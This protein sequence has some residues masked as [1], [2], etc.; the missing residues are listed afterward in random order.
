MT[1]VVIIEKTGIIK[2]NEC[3]DINNLYKLCGFRKVDGFELRHTWENLSLN[4]SKY[5]VSVY[6]RNDGKANTENKYDMPPP[7]DNDLYYGNLAIVNKDQNNNLKDLTVNEWNKIYE[8]LFGGFENLDDYDDDDAEEDELENIS[9]E[10]KTKV[11]G[12]LKDGFVV[13]NSDDED[14]GEN[15]DDDDLSFDEDDSSENSNNK[16]EVIEDDEEDDVDGFG[17]ELEYEEYEYSDEN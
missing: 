9:S 4:N 3:K 1:S 15:E 11:G 2:Q 10:L 5:N 16:N 12:Y 7:I 6:S 17:S 13:D 8:H 14:D